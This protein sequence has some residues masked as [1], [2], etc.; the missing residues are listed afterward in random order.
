MTLPQPSNAP[1]PPAF[2]AAA[3]PCPTCRR[4]AF[5]TIMA[6]VLIGLVVASLAAVTAAVTADVRRTRQLGADTQFRQ[7]LLA[8]AAD[9]AAHAKAWGD[10]PAPQSWALALP[11]ALTEQGYRVQLSVVLPSA[12]PGAD[13]VEVRVDATGP[14]LT[15]LQTLRFVRSAEEWKLRDVG[16]G[17]DE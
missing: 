9:A 17:I 8:G 4:R 6:I 3:A 5:A 7:L 2:S 13:A 15:K 1:G 16:R 11:Q 12:P 14:N 10:A